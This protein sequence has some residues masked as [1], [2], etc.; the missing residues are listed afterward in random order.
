MTQKFRRF[1]Q[2]HENGTY[3]G[4]VPGLRKVPSTNR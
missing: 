4:T 1:A 3:A 2:K